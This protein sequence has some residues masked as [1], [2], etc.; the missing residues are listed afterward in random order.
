MNIFK[1][2]YDKNYTVIIGCGRLGSYLAQVLSSQNKNV[3]ILDKEKKSFDRLSGNFGGLSICASG[4][5][6]DVLEE[7]NIKKASAVI[8]VTDN[9]N[10]NIMIA[11]IVK[12][13]FNV[14]NVL[15]RLY[16][17]ERDMVYRKLGIRTICP[18]TLSATEIE[19]FLD[20]SRI[21]RINLERKIANA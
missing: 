21:N 5:D 1:K 12:Y 18:S 4:L 10:T 8:V 20:S 9:D 17:P 6:L 11:Q 15:A 13:M 16:D 2:D 3:I 7:I 14:E 19:N